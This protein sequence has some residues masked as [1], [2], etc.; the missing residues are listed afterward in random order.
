MELEVE[1]QS[2]RNTFD[3]FVTAVKDSDFTSYLKLHSEDVVS[4]VNEE[5]FVRNSER[6]RSHQFDFEL[7]RIEFDGRFATVSFNVTPGD[8]AEEHKDQ[9][10]VTLIRDDKRWSLY[11]T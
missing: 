5:L 6:A 11:E 10:E 1:V 2:V 8:G 3:A 7:E 9:A 4:E